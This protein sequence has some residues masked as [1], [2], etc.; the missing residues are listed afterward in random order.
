MSLASFLTV[1][2]GYCQPGIGNL[3]IEFT[4]TVP[5]G[6]VFYRLV[7]SDTGRI[8]VTATEEFA[9]K[10]TITRN[11]VIDMPDRNLW[12]RLEV[13]RIIGGVETVDA[14]YPFP[15]WTWYEVVVSDETVLG[16][17]AP[18]DWTSYIAKMKYVGNGDEALPVN[19]R[20]RLL[21][22]PDLEV[23]SLDN[24]ATYYVVATGEMQPDVY[25]PETF[26]LALAFQVPPL[27]YKPY[28][29]K[30]QWFGQ[31]LP[32]DSYS[33]AL[34]PGLSAGATFILAKPV[35]VTVTGEA[36]E[37]PQAPG[38]WTSFSA[39]ITDEEGQSLPEK[40]YVQLML[41]TP[42]AIPVAFKNEFLGKGD[43]VETEFTTEYAPI[44]PDTLTVYVNDVPVADYTV[45]FQVGRIVFNVPP[46]KNAVVT[47]DYTAECQTFPV[48]GVNLKRDVYFNNKAKF[49]FKV[50]DGLSAGSYSVWLQWKDQVIGD[51]KYLAGTGAGATLD[52]LSDVRS[53]TVVNE[54]TM[55]DENETSKAAPGVKLSYSAT[56]TDGLGNA[57]PEKA[58]VKL[59]FKP[60]LICAVEEYLKPL[61][62]YV[63][64]TGVWLN[65][66]SGNFK[67]FGKGSRWAQVGFEIKDVEAG[68]FESPKLYLEVLS[69][70]DVR[71]TVE[72]FA[73]GD[74]SVELWYGD[75]MLTG[76]VEEKTPPE[77]VFNA[78]F[79]MVVSRVSLV[80]DVYDKNVKTANIAF[81]VPNL[82]VGTHMLKLEWLN[83]VV[84]NVKYLE[85]HSTGIIFEVILPTEIVVTDEKA[86]NQA[87]GQWTTYTATMVDE[88]GNVLPRS[89]Y[90]KLFVDEVQVA[91]VNLDENVYNTD[92]KEVAIAFQ[93]PE[94]MAAGWKTIKLK[95]EA[96]VA[97]GKSFPAGESSGI[98]FG[99]TGDVKHIEVAG[100]E[101]EKPHLTPTLKTTCFV[102][103]AVVETG[104]RVPETLPLTL[105]LG[106]WEP[107]GTYPD[108]YDDQGRVCISFT[109]PENI[110][111]GIYPLKL[112][113]RSY[114]LVT[115]DNPLGVKYE[116]GSHVVD[117]SVVPAKK[118]VVS[119][120]AV[121]HPQAPGQWV[122]YVATVEDE[123]GNPLP[124]DFYVSLLMEGLENVGVNMI[125]NV[126]DPSTK[127]VKIAFQTPDLAEGYYPIKLSWET[128]VI[129]GDG[130]MY[131]ESSGATFHLTR[132]VRMVNV[133]SEYVEKT[134][135]SPGEGTS[136]FATVFD[137][138]VEAMLSSFAVEL[139]LDDA[140]KTVV[141]ACM[142]ASD[143]YN[144]ETR[145]VAIAF[146]VPLTLPS[147][148]YRVK[149]RWT[150]QV[151]NSIKY[152]AGESEGAIFQVL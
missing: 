21:L 2:I 44:V 54:K 143:V 59:V 137:E 105:Q 96:Q 126:Y 1:E 17:A 76:A 24:P 135:L 74:Y 136:Y 151:C 148:M 92:K 121:E 106:D 34:P 103:M 37:H 124:P 120:E 84:D 68:N 93:V 57:L 78:S 94:T 16:A 71:I 132:D 29:L 147:G 112:E 133:T 142:F 110:A 119:D 46:E 30:L 102:E 77:N 65:S 5:P 48:G 11:F 53:I 19:F 69:P 66:F 72:N 141:A 67:I 73:D 38:H 99:V 98:Q 64:N 61:K 125:G 13:G 58:G 51:K 25:S 128:Q 131:G 50:P 80:P 81:E 108:V 123:N 41:Y 134:P 145:Q 27:D 113:W 100:V 42:T 28:P 111:P 35:S 114:V 129:G 87:A 138:R 56:I 39:L 88:D 6:T 127:K 14:Y 4:V 149:L 79:E 26:D 36:V 49:A 45:D 8:L 83:M 10:S 18:G 97:D 86:F 63:K 140:D 90:V 47:C 23:F 146:Q 75:T 82:P 15:V 104:D 55:F 3:K 9:S 31:A 139:F 91:G 150:S 130:Y 89:F 117:V 52:V 85:G 7:D 107:V 101:L 122:S 32:K 152:E 40:F 33:F 12:L 144:P 62:V 118:V 43:G 60:S 116:G 20:V 115:A 95:W 109:V 70:T 22:I